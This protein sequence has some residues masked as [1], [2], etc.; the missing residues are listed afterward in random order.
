MQGKSP[1][2]GT[3]G[4]EESEPQPQ[5]K[6]RIDAWNGFEMHSFFRLFS[7]SIARR[8]TQEM[9]GARGAEYRLVSRQIPECISGRV[10]SIHAIPEG[11]NLPFSKS[12]TCNGR[13]ECVKKCHPASRGSIK[14]CEQ[15]PSSLSWQ[16]SGF[17]SIQTTDFGLG[18]VVT[19][20][21]IQKES[22]V[23]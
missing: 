14:W 2:E 13:L 9:E 11:G 3:S 19:V 23:A 16:P 17:V 4:F 10:N 6:E 15:S 8:F 20:R 21:R 1:A 18:A 7:D 5:A 12:M 22:N